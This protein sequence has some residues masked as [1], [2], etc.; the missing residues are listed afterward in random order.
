MEIA[1]YLEDP[2]DEEHANSDFENRPQG[3]DDGDDETDNEADAD[4]ECR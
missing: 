2:I 1:Q 4:E 3:S